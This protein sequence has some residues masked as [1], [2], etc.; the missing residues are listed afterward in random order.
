MG[1]KPST[2]VQ[3][4]GRSCIRSQ[5]RAKKTCS[6]SVDG[7]AIRWLTDHIGPL[8]S[9]TVGLARSWQR[10]VLDTQKEVVTTWFHQN[11]EDPA[12]STPHDSSEGGYQFIWGGPYDAEEVLW[13]EFGPHGI[14][15]DVIN[16]VVRD[17]TEDGLFEWA[18]THRRLAGQRDD[19][20]DDVWYP[21]PISQPILGYPRQEDDARADVLRRLEA[22]ERAVETLNDDPPVLGNN[23]KIWTKE[24][25]PFS[26]G[27]YRDI[28]R[29]ARRFG[30]Q[31]NDSDA[32]PEA[33]R[34]DVS[35]LKDLTIRLGRWLMDRLT[36][37]ADALAKALG[38]ALAAKLVGLY[39]A[40]VEVCQ[41]VA[42]WIGLL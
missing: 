9:Q 30:Q 7:R 29:I 38:V 3:R 17:V 22:L 14:L 25:P 28:D 2:G 27:D 35:K 6:H 32:D 41:A 1:T 31:A 37:T 16:E 33:L 24:T 5:Q 4:P 19:L 26:P 23:S 20:L 39:E 10:W 34:E 15:E 42:N 40:M 36:S 21:L 11:F 8:T 13:D 12:Q 18:P